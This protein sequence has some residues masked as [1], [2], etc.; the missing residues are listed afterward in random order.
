MKQMY[1]LVITDKIA[2]CTAFYK[3]HFGFISVFEQDWYVQLLHQASGTELAFM[4]PDA[5][6]QPKELHAAFQGS[7]LVLSIEV[8]DA[9]MEYSRLQ[10]KKLD[11]IVSLKDE[12]WG[13][14]HFIIRD[15]SGTYVDVVQ[16]LTA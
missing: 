1:P 11:E 6:N 7:G 12:P 4:V 14:R 10:S 9:Q 2:E 15:P 5:Q 13:Q 16:Q 8:D 3:D